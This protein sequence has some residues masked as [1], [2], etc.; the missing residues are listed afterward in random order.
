[1]RP[2]YERPGRPC[3][4]DDFQEEA[5][6]MVHDSPRSLKHVLNEIKKTLGKV[7]SK[8]SLKRLCKKAKLSWKRVRKSL[9]KK[10]NPELFRESEQM[11]EEL[12]KQEDNGDINLYFFD[13]SGF[14][15][16][17]CVPYAWQPINQTIEIP[18]AKS[19]G[20]N[21]WN[22][23]LITFMYFII[24]SFTGPHDSSIDQDVCQK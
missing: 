14:T 20:L 8:S 17:P 24:T 18:S 4:T 1:M 15:L 13:E 12:V 19:K 5:I 16:E 6:Q 23:N 21:V 11:I 22:E 7:I 10:R 2:C 9:K 3:S